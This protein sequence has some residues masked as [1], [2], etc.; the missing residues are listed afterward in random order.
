MEPLTFCGKPELNKSNNKTKTN[1]KRHQKSKK[2]NQT[3]PSGAKSNKAKGYKVPQTEKI[4]DQKQ[5]SYKPWTER[6][7]EKFA[8]LIEESLLV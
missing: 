3:K 7:K 1:S 6:Q 5:A 4:L 2:G 8:K